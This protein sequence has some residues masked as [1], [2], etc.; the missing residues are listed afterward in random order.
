MSK[1]II[2]G[3]FVVVCVLIFIKKYKNNIQSQPPVQTR[4]TCGKNE[5]FSKYHGACKPCLSPM[6]MLNGI[7]VDCRNTRSIEING[8]C[9]KCLSHEYPFNGKCTGCVSPLGFL[10]GG[11]I[12]C[13]MMGLTL[14]DGKC[15]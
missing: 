11:C 2:I 13:S 4:L 6:G 7:C 9:V 15:I 5:Y 8:E 10:N 12:N 3:V 14:K 1:N